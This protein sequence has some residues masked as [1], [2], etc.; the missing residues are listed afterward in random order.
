MAFLSTHQDS[1]KPSSGQHKLLLVDD[2]PMVIALLGKTLEGF[3]RLQFATSGAD[4]LRLAHTFVPDLILLDIEMPDIGGFE[5]CRALKANPLLADVPVIFITSHD[6]GEHEVTGLALGGVDFICKPLRPARVV[7]RVQ[8]HLR[9]KDM[10]DAL[11]RSAY[12]DGLT[13]IA[14]RRHFDEQLGREWRRAERTA[15]PMSLLMVDVDAFKKYNDHYGHPAGDKCLQRVAM[16]VLKAGHRPGD[17]AARFGGEE[18]ALVL[19]QTD[20]T[21]AEI[22]AMHLLEEVD[23]LALPHAASP[24]HPF[25]SVSVGVTSFD[26]RCE[27]WLGQPADSRF[28]TLGDHRPVADLLRAAD[29]A[30][31][32]AK[33]AGRRR[34]HFLCMDDVDVPGRSA[35]LSRRRQPVMPLVVADGPSRV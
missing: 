10:A 12:L 33:Q 9:M 13:G 15:S 29:Q 16:T 4:A 6:A 2:D 1:E 31:Y 5:V 7:A 21:G 24:A 14:N 11:R 28:G 30:L 32:A 19:P 23:A 27:G 34:A 20:A 25:V 18:F 26:A 3:G 35:C 22:V 8:M 17:L